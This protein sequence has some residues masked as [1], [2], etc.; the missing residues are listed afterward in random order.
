MTNTIILPWP[1]KELSPN[2]RVHWAVK[3]KAS[4]KY[5]EDARLLCFEAKLVAP[6]VKKI[7]LW[8][9]FNPPQRRNYDDDNMLARFKPQ[10]DG[11]ADYLGIDDKCFVSHPYVRD[12]DVT[13]KGT[14][15]VMLTG[16]PDDC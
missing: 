5:R 10:R 12:F 7:H 11:I 3:S 6:E 16:G 2:G 14:V 9:Y 8:I 13:K 1:P 15:E 4:K